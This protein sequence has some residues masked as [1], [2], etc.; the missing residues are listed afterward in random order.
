MIIRSPWPSIDVAALPVT[1]YVLEHARDHA[2]RTA[3]V[4]AV[5]GRRLTYGALDAAI[6]RTAAGLAARGFGS[7]DVFGIY[8]PNMPE[9]ALA[10]HGAAR[11][12]RRDHD[13]QPAL[14]RRRAGHPAPRLRR[15]VPVHR[16]RPHRQGARGRGAR[17]ASREIFVFGEAE[18]ATPFAD[19]LA[20]LARRARPARP[21]PTRTREPGRPGRAARTRAA[22]PA[23]QGRD[24]HPPQPGRQ[25]RADVSG[26]CRTS[27]EDD[28]LI[29]RAAVLPHLRHRSCS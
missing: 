9:Y 23:A 3:L 29:A 2:D 19:V 5:T 14:H 17:R 12:G 10:F 24:A 27:R 26:R 7:G 13:R 21:L 18:G 22:R 6:A 25:H 15:E 1:D 4:D 20:A 8:S 16:A 28:T 11:P